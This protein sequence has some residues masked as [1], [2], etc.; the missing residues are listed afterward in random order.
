MKDMN[1]FFAKRLLAVSALVVCIALTSNVFALP[2]FTPHIPDRSGEYVFYRDYSFPRESYVGFLTYDDSTYAARYFAPR[3][4]AKNLVEENV[5][6]YFTLDP[7]SDY[8]NMTGERIGNAITQEQ[9]DIVNYLHDLVYEFNARRIRADNVNPATANIFGKKYL[10]SG[11]S[12]SQDYAQ[13]GGKVH[14]IFDYLVPLFNIK[15]II[16]NDNTVILEAV[17]IGTLQSSNDT[18]FTSFAG[19]PD[20]TKSAAS[21]KKSWTPDKSAKKNKATIN[22]QQVSLDSSWT[23]SMENLWLLGDEALL[24]M[25]TANATPEQLL[26][27][28]IQNANWKNVAVSKSGKSYTLSSTYYQPT[29]G[30]IMK[31]FRII[32]EMSDGTCA[33]F[34][35][36]I[37]NNTYE[38]NKKYFDEIVKSYKAK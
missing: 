29:S 31:G 21:T 16:S 1:N 6:I 20:S 38:A 2:G 24:S 18:T 37:F 15:K 12:V 3:D 9:T 35:L 10:D 11:L 22:T 7:N 25:S 13:F 36:T 32:T 27:M 8:I 5:L 34:M 28:T 23:N 26:R 30:N 4:P 14:I 17:T 33:I 19:I